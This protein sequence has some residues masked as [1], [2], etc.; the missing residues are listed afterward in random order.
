MKK[1]L[2]VVLLA[3]C[4]AA[5]GEED[6]TS[7]QALRKI[8]LALF[9]ESS[10]K[11]GDKLRAEADKLCPGIELAY[12][13]IDKASKALKAGYRAEAKKDLQE[14]I[15]ACPRAWEVLRWMAYD[16]GYGLHKDVITLMVALDGD[17]AA[18]LKTKPVDK[19]AE[20]AK[21]VQIRNEGIKQLALYLSII[22]YRKAH[23]EE[24]EQSQAMANLAKENYQ[25][26]EEDAK[27]FKVKLTENDMRSPE[28]LRIAF[29][30]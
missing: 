1:M 26:T 4:F 2:L 10:G 20:D 28:T 23:K 6:L 16:D 19:K 9:N 18:E 8:D 15:K 12:E 5:Y 29:E 30:K 3:F 13:N 17:H 7:K 21:Q 22:D 24:F 11:N 25:I 14:A 27:P